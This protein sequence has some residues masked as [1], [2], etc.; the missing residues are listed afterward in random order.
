MGCIIIQIQTGCFKQLHTD[1][2]TEIM[3]L[4]WQLSNSTFAL[5]G[6]AAGAGAGAGL[7]IAHSREGFLQAVIE[8]VVF[9]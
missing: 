1:V 7:A 2:N 6:E 4:R 8:G 9:A 3:C 5:V